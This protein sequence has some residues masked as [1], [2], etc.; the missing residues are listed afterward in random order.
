MN[1]PLDSNLILV[2]AIVLA[3]P[4]Y[5]WLQVARRKQNVIRFKVRRICLY[6]A[7]VMIGIAII[8]QYGYTTLEAGIFSIAAG[9]ALAFILIR[10]PSNSR[11]IPAK[12]RRE[13]I[14][15]DLKGE[16]FDPNVHDI[17]HI[18]PFSKGGDHTVENLRVVHRSENR[19]RGAKMPTLKDFH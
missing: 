15:R 2:I 13:V 19:R 7:V 6:L 4:T 17:D 10:P 16:P 1:E 5:Y 3:L 8:P 14:A 12:V 11:R 18:V 9:T